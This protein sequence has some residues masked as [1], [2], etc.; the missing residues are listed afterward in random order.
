[1]GRERAAAVRADTRRG[2]APAVQLS[3]TVRERATTGER[4]RTFTVESQRIR[5]RRRATSFITGEM[6]AIDFA[7]SALDASRAEF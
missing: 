5:M 2:A 6:R 3:R 7:A 1:M 4:R